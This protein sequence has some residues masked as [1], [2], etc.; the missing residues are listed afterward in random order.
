MAD[1]FTRFDLIVGPT[2][3]VQPFS[4][5]TE[6]VREIDGHAMSDYIEWMQA[7]SWITVTC[8]P[9]LSL[10]APFADDLPVGAQLI[11]PMR[12]DKFLLSAAKAIEA[13]TEYAAR[14]PELGD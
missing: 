2:T 1:L 4:L 5:D 8:C 11:A 7:C 12:A 13:A 6:W 14:A 3:Q 10:P 9:C